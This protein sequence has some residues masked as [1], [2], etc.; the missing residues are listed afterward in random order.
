MKKTL[1]VLFFFISIISYSQYTLIPD[2]EFEHYLIYQG[3][4]TGAV[5]GKVLTSAIANIKEIYFFPGAANINIKDLTGIEDFK[6]LEKLNC[7]NCNLTTLDLSK[8]TFLTELICENNKLTNFNLKGCVNLKMINCNGNKFTSLDVSEATNLKTLYCRGAKLTNLNLNTNLT[9]LDCSY[10]QLSFLDLSNC[11]SLEV[12]ACQNN[13]FTKLD[14]S[15]NINLTG[16]SCLE[17]R[18]TNLDVSKNSKLMELFCENNSINNLDLTNNTELIFLKCSRNLLTNLDTSQNTK[19]TN[20]YCNNNQITNLNISKNRELNTLYCENNNLSNLDTFKNIN[21]RNLFCYDNKLISLNTS[22]NPQLNILYCHN[23]LITS[24]DVSI[25]NNLEIF[26][27]TNNKLNYLDIRNSRS[28]NWWGYTNDWSSNPDLGCIYVPDANFFNAFYSNRKDDT[29][30]YFDGIPPKFELTSQTVCSKQNPTLNDIAVTGYNIKWFDSLINGNELPY[31]TGLT[32]GT[33]YYAMNTA[34]SCKTLRS[35]VTITFQPI[36]P[37]SANTSQNLCNI[38]NPSLDNLSITGIAIQWY[39][40][41]NDGDLLPNNTSLVSGTTYFASQTQNGC[42]SSR[43]AILVNLLNIN[44]PTTTSPQTF[45]IQQNATLSSIT[46]AGQNI[47]W[48]DALANGTLL[49]TT[50]LLQNGTTYYASQTINGCESERI[51]VAINIQ[52]TAAPTGS[53]NQTFCTSQIP[54]LN[55]IVISGT[56]V[57]WYDNTE[58]LLSNATPLQDGVTYYASQ[59]ENSC[60]STN[61]LA[62]TVS[63]INTLPANDYAELFCDDLNDGSEKVNLS[64]YNSKLIS[65]TSRYTFSYYSSISAAENESVSNQITNFSNFNLVLGDNK[66]YVRINSNTP[67]YAIAVLKLSVVAKPLIPIPDIVPICE[68]N[69]ISINAGSATDSF[70]WSTGETTPSIVIANPGEYAV[71]VT[72]NYSTISCSSSKKFSVIKSTIAT[73]ISIATQDWTDKNNVIS[74]YVYGP[75]SYEYSVDGIRYQDSNE[76]QNLISGTYTVYVKD[77]N[78]CGIVTDKVYLLMYPKFFT[79]NGDGY[80]DTWSI[81]FSDTE[82]ELS[83]QLFDRYGKLITVLNQNQTWDGTFNGHELP[84]TD[85]WFIVTRADGKVYKGHF[86]LKR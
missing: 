45:C 29:A 6:A 64:D 48:Y 51:P 44:E 24:L 79:P 9:Y 50:T 54:T 78:G 59:T 63:L 30:Y 21:L 61:R 19:L 52:N 1:L 40:A 13:N 74:V 39:N 37:P 67:C 83:L 14:V 65:N 85:Y 82:V 49:L 28:I 43:V 36:S 81:H 27:C 86:T 84:S 7:T 41:V 66:I 12:L 56:A 73:I 62:V 18:L 25:N 32:E 55:T 72:K 20:L 11:I 76:F 42:E 75:G 38:T 47:K 17:N 35:P 60:E 68:N 3:Y 46:I 77:K 22:Q 16:L 8:N 31:T 53:Q 57:K 23:N 2:P 4:D 80:N 71:T 58:T 70:S 15:K 34:G 5:D 26:R 69:T 10:N 33:T